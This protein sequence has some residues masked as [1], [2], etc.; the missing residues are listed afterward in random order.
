MQVGR[1][2]RDCPTA[3]RENNVTADRQD[4]GP[5]VYTAGGGGRVGGERGG[6]PRVRRA[7]TQA[8]SVWDFRDL[9]T[10]TV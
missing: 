1:T 7:E 2:P 10:F 8:V 3:K 9:V 6:H 5:T 4:R